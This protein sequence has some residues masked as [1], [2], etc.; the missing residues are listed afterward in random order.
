M[1][2]ND[3]APGTETCGCCSGT[4]VRTPGVVTNR[5]GLPEIAYRSGT[6][7]DFLA[8]LLAGLSG[9]DVP[10][11]SAL[12]SHDRDDPTIALIDAWA[13]ACDVL[14]F[15]T[16]R[17]ANESYLRTATDRTSLQELGKLIGYRLNPGVAAETYLAFTLAAPARD[18]ARRAA[19]PGSAPPGGARRRRA[20]DR[21]ARAEHP[22]AR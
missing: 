1:S 2:G 15:Y 10:T 4:T 5:P 11:L 20:A 18:S 9:K 13:V 3:A 16:E 21:A 17:L 8:S 7:G 14:T 19:R 22:R 12:R 6:H